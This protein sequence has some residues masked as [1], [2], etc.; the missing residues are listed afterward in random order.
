M[1][2]AIQGYDPFLGFYLLVG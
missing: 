2:E 1:I